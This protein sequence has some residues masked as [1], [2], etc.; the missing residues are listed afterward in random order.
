MY[1]FSHNI[2]YLLI[3]G[4]GFGFIS[5]GQAKEPGNINEGAYIYKGD[6]IVRITFDTLRNTLAR[7]ISERGVNGAV[8]YCKTNAKLL[9]E[10]YSGKSIHISRVAAK[11]RNP[12]NK[13]DSFDI[14]QWNLYTDK[15]SRGDSL[16]STVISKGE[17]IY[18]YKPILLQ[19][20]C[21]V[22]H[23]EAGKDISPDIVSRIDSL[24]PGDLAR[25]FKPGDL[26]GMWKIAFKK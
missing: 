1:R 13:P 18:Y 3:L 16:T 9:T 15:K 17:M 11:Y 6:S 14:V 24:Y 10:T 26:R 4:L 23:G 25:G 8:A 12:E 7:T 22:C 21:V 2:I 5:C 19:P 20:M